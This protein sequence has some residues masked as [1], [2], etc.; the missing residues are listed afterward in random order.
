MPIP[1]KFG[2]KTET[3]P[4]PEDAKEDLPDG[5]VTFLVGKKRC[6]ITAPKNLLAVRSE[7]FNNMFSIGMKERDAEEVP[8][9]EE[10]PEAFKHWST[11]AFGLWTEQWAKLY[12]AESESRRI[13]T[14][15]TMTMIWKTRRNRVKAHKI[16]QAM[17]CKVSSTK[18]NIRRKH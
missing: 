10:D 5:K 4:K 13:I 14:T 12:D 15:I 2:M 9:P 3:L 8:M 6:E 7:V 18:L 17:S 16:R 11:E 1:I